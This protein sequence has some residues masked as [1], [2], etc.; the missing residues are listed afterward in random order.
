[1]QELQKTF[2]VFL[3]VI[4]THEL[5][6]VFLSPKSTP[7]LDLMM[8]LLLYNCCNHKDIIVRKVECK[9]LGFYKFAYKLFALM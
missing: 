2:F 5:S 1:M 7:H 6:S 4:A 9:I 8:Q 3:N